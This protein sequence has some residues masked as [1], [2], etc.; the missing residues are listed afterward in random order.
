M[1]KEVSGQGLV[2]VSETWRRCTCYD[3]V[4]GQQDADNNEQ[5][6]IYL[7]SPNN[8]L[9]N[10][11]VSGMENAVFVNQAGRTMSGSDKSRGKVC[12]VNQPIGETRGNTFKLNIGFGWYGNNLWLAIQP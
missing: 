6:G 3:C 4:N 1:L 11:V 12:P 2:N 8:K 5:A 10:N 9:L 7:V